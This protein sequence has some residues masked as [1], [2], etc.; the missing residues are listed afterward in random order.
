MFDY[1]IHTSVSFD[2]TES[3]E[4]VIA[5]ARAAGL[6]EICFT[7]HYDFHTDPT[8]AH[9]LFTKE[10]YDAAY[11]KLECD[12]ISV[13]R[14]VEF[15]LTTWDAPQLRALEAE[16]GF[17][18]VIGSVHYVDGYDPYL[19]EYWVGKT[20]EYAFRRYLEHMLDCVRAHS[21][22]D[23]LGHM[24]YVCKSPN[25][26]TRSPLFYNDYREICDEIM[27]EL[28]KKGRGMEINTS[29]CDRVGEFLPNADFLRRFREL[30]GE[31]VTLGSDSHTCD[32]VGQYS[33]EALAI[34]KDIF[35]YVCTFDKRK[36]IF[37]KL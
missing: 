35:G 23:V 34:L 20:P 2:S 22:F 7:D 37:H 29:G 25:N 18:F 36:P 6:R 1:H 21:D 12:G 17:D 30:G 24:N 9:N 27:R 26:P 19:K 10:S 3:A 32:R 14:G 4:N 16:Y 33:A 15:G 5:A 28:V 31:I 13:K 8:D 11:A